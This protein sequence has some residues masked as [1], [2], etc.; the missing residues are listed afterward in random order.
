MEKKHFQKYKSFY[1]AGIFMI[2]WITGALIS[3]FVNA[4]QSNL[5]QK[6]QNE[7]II[8]SEK[9]NTTNYKNSINYLN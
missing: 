7:I 3:H 4:K 9:V 5:E 1:N 8:N 2:S 6:T